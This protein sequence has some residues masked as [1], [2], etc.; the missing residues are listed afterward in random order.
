[1]SKIP[2]DE[3]NAPLIKM[4]EQARIDGFTAVIAAVRIIGTNEPLA[5]DLIKQGQ[6]LISASFRF[7]MLLQMLNAVTA[8]DNM[9]EWVEEVQHNGDEFVNIMKRHGPQVKNLLDMARKI[10]EERRNARSKT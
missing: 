6:E 10:V 7:E 2:R 3:R 5:S 1:M 9:L 8:T 4:C